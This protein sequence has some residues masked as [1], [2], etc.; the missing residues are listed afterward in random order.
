M[1][2]AHLFS[3][4]VSLTLSHSLILLLRVSRVW[5]LACVFV[6]V[7]QAAGGVGAATRV[8]V[9]AKLGHG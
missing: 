1:R 4:P 5:E 9:L 7:A 8:R 2:E 3:P 6:Q